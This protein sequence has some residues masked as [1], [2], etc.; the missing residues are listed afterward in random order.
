MS[1]GVKVHKVIWSRKAQ[2]DVWAFHEYLVREKLYEP[3]YA[4]LL[5]TRIFQSP[6]HLARFPRL[7][8]EAPLYGEG[9]RKIVVLGHLVLYEIDDAQKV[10]RIL[11]VVGQRQAPRK[12]R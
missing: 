7:R 1:K 2:E 4:D 8:S 12:L 9:V 11:A 5:C 10:I 3:D 6:N